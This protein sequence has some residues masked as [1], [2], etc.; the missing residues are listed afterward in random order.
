MYAFRVLIAVL[1][2]SSVSLPVSAAPPTLQTEVEESSRP[3]RPVAMSQHHI[4]KIGSTIYCA[5]GGGYTDKIDTSKQVF[6]YNPSQDIWSQ[7]S[8]CPILEFG[9]T[10][11]DDG[12][13]VTVGGCRA[14]QV[15]PHQWC[16]CISRIW[17]M[18]EFHHPTPAHSTLL[19][20]SIHFT[21]QQWRTHSLG[22]GQ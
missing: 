15:T 12:K 10:Q 1:P 16:L 20:N 5:C 4:V 3:P 19:P 11:L 9:L 21:N 18:G 7:L 22:H 17:N 6:Q 13:L 2:C 14:S 8:I